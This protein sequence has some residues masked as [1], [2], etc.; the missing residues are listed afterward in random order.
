MAWYIENILYVE[1]PKDATRK[2]VELINEFDKFADHKINTHKSV[3]FPYT[4]NKLSKRKIKETFTIT[5]KGIK[6]PGINLPKEVK[7]LCSENIRLWWRKL[8]KTQTDRK[9]C[10]VL[11]LE[12]LILLKWPYYTRQYTDSVH[13]LSKYQ[14]HFFVENR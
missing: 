10:H 6:Y 13:S 14:R 9:L 12:E 4:N 3:A 1:N 2:L 11:G 7:D 8:K 5:S